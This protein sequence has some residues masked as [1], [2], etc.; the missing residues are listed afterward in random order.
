MMIKTRPAINNEPRLYSLDGEVLTV[1][2][3]DETHTLDFAALLPNPGDKAEGP[4]RLEDEEGT[5]IIDTA[6]RDNAGELHVTI[7]ES[8][9][10]GLHWDY[11]DWHNG[12]PP[13]L[14]TDGEYASK[15]VAK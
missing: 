7:F 2:Y 12:V 11:S 5:R 8:V 13:A 4:W 6:E 1:T 9:P 3:N 10:G 14:N 15:K